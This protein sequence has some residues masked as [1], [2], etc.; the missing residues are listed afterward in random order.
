MNWPQSFKPKY[1]SLTYLLSLFLT[2]FFSCEINYDGDERLLVTGRILN[3]N[4]LPIP[5]QDV[6]FW[7]YKGSG[8]GGDD[9]LISLTATDN[10]GQ[11]LMLIPSPNNEDGF[12][13]KISDPDT[14]YQHKILHRI[15]DKNFTN[16]EY[17]IGD[18]VLYQHHVITNAYITFNKTTVN[19]S[20]MDVK[21][22][23]DADYLV[24]VNE[25]EIYYGDYEPTLAHDY[26]KNVPLNSTLTITYTV[27]DNSTETLSTHEATVTINNE[28]LEYIINY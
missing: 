11:F 15:L 17:N 23:G 7:I 16:Y 13:L 9:D 24:W 6:E 25:P 1:L 3:E 22:K 12:E 19:T 4:N 5:N 27:R 2:L 14:I 20:L 8:A 26:Y 18:I 21:F 28:N 10:N